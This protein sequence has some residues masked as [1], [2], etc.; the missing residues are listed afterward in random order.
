[1]MPA[2]QM[3]KVRG[4]NSPVTQMLKHHLASTLPHDALKA[5][6]GR[7]SRTVGGGR[8]PLPSA[9][10]RGR[11]GTAPSGSLF[12]RLPSAGGPRSR[13]SSIHS[14]NPSRGH[15]PLSVSSSS[16]KSLR[17]SP[18]AGAGGGAGAGAGARRRSSARRQQPPSPLGDSRAR[19]RLA[20]VGRQR[21]TGSEARARPRSSARTSTRTSAQASPGIAVGAGRMEGLRVDTGASATTAAAADRASD[22]PEPSKSHTVVKPL[23]EQD[24][25]RE[26]RVP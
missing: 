15:S 23:S 2:K 14:M 21:K 5:M 19:T 22:T 24:R 18:T 26:C 10:S 9:R 4:P 1:M 25:A 6:Q 3:E 8:S 16:R 7:S 11:P 13:Q 17:R 20:S 12:G